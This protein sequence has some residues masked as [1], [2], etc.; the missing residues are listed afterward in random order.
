MRRLLLV[1]VLLVAGV[2]GLG[3]YRGWFHLSTGEA[4]GKS[5]IPVTVDRDKIEQDK[6]KAKEKVHEVE[7]QV[8]EKVNAPAAAG[9][10][11]APRP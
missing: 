11:A 8:K 9:K 3:F 4:D 5:N 7:Q 2:V 1:L 6:E 10:G